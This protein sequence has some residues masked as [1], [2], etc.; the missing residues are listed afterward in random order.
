MSRTSIGSVVATAFSNAIGKAFPSQNYAAAVTPC[1]S[2]RFG[3]YQCNSA[4]QIFRQLK[5]VEGAP[6][7]PQATAQ[8]IADNLDTAIFEKVE[9]IKSGFIN[10]F[11]S[12]KFTSARLNDVLK[13]GIQPPE[14]PKRKVVIDFSSPNIAKEMHVGHLRSTIIGESLCRM[15]EFL[16][17]DVLR[18]N[19][20]GDWGTQFGMLIAYLKEEFPDFLENPP[21]IADLQA[22]YRAAKT[23]FDKDEEFKGRAHGEVVALQSGDK[24]NL[25]AW[26]MICDISRM[27]F[28]KIY[29]RLDVKLDEMGESFYNPHIPNVLKI[30]EDQGLVQDDQGAKC[31]F[32]PIKSYPL[33]VRKSDGGYTYDSTD[34][35]AIWYRIFQQKADW[36][37]YVVDSGQGEHF[38][39][40]FDAAKAAG[41]ITDKIRVDHVGFGVVLGEDGKRLKTRS[42]DVVRLVDL[43][44]EA[45]E[46]A[47]K[48]LESREE[49]DSKLGLSEQELSEM[50]SIIGHGAVRYA[51]LKSNRLTD[52]M[53]SYDRM[54][55]LKGNTAVYL[56]YAHARISSV[57]RKA[58]V[59]TEAMKAVTLIDLEHD[60]EVDLALDILRFGD[61]TLEAAEL[62]MPHKICEYAYG[63]AT[64]FSAFYRDCHIV[65]S[66]KQDSRLLLCELTAMT[67]R[68][69]F[70]LLG[71]TPLYRI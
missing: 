43:L 60:S 20:V 10:V 31:I 61:T 46:R 47:K 21:K 57:A 15:L 9:V 16:G 50:A 55:D 64:K 67:L 42:G 11:L 63:L 54:L 36:I 12:K 71:I 59:D 45:V 51:D 5:G 65:G 48:Q 41:W 14:V 18:I 3:H 8:V 44:D 34:M 49:G 68:K 4:M 66:E 32:R 56:E 27:E 28:E 53:F 19:H 25:T 69:A 24:N 2:A 7:S 23:R 38:E 22:F 33:I 1:S 29:N 13:S 58:G 39:L 17:H 62:L 40:V 30:L 52:Y 37:I 70:Y 26:K 35:T 6:A